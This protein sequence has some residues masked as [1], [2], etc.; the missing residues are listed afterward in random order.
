M[1]SIQ[2]V[3]KTDLARNTRQIISK[4]QRGQ[5]ILIENHGQAEVAILDVL[6]YYVLR[7][8][9][10]YYTHPP[11]LSGKGISRDAMLGIEDPQSAYDLVL[12]SYLAGRISLGRTAE[13]LELPTLDLQTR[14]MRLDVPLNLGAKDKR[15]A[16]SEAEAARNS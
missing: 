8:V 11:R 5:T 10:A 13:L 1:E 9:A 3:R 15:D 7:A 6:D 14:F 16:K 12:A 2:R 4:V